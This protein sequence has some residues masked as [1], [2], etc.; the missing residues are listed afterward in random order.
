[1]DKLLARFW[2][3]DRAFFYALITKYEFAGVTG[4]EE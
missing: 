2:I 1:M 3:I 4:S